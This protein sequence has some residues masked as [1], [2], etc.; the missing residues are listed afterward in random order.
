ML[1]PHGR[2]AEAQQPASPP[3]SAANISQPSASQTVSKPPNS[4]QPASNPA[5]RG[6]A[7]QE[8]TTSDAQATFVSRVN[9]VPIT[10]VVRDDN[11]HAI[12]TLKKEDFRLLDNGKPQYISRFSVE[13]PSKPMALEKETADPDAPKPEGGTA[14]LEVA[15]RFVAYLFD[16]VHASWEDLAR[17][18][19]A[20]ARQI[21]TSLLATDR[22][23]VYTTSGQTMQ[24]FTN[25]Q[26][27]LQETLLLLRSRPIAGGA[28]GPTDCPRV[29]YYMADLL[30]NREDQEAWQVAIAETYACASLDP[31]TTPVTVVRA[32]VQMAASRALNSGSHET[33]IALDVL[34]K[35]VRRISAMPGQR[36]IIL[37]SPGFLAPDLHQD[38]SDV[39]SKAIRAKVIVSTLDARGLW[40]DSTYSASEVTPAGGRGCNR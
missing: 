31:A 4:E 3:P 26:A 11:G 19:D 5:A 16:D 33:R 30:I 25:D 36:T 27:K 15:T 21:A 13:N 32:M 14:T 10:V 2:R 17:T 34:G 28:A 29:S 35:I 6:K 20:A 38:I 39:I 22:A 9:L 23:A 7:E 8:V 40:T 18:R 1:F 24:E 37:A 12:G